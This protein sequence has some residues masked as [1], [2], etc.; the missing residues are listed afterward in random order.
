MAEKTYALFR[1]H[2]PPQRKKGNKNLAYLNIPQGVFISSEYL[3]NT[4]EKLGQGGCDREHHTHAELM[5][6]GVAS[7]VVV[8]R[9]QE[10]FPHAR[11]LISS[12]TDLIS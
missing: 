4:L 1:Y 11:A 5:T 6:H 12:N 8:S 7:N 9:S 10:L 2:P 3:L